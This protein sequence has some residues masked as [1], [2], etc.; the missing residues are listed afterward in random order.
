MVWPQSWGIHFR[1]TGG[2]IVSR[3][4]SWDR[5]SALLFA[6]LVLLVAF[7]F[8]QY[9]N[10]FDAEVQDVYGR[11]IVS[12][13]ASFGHDR[14]AL[15]YIDLFYYGGLFDTLA[16]LVN[17]VSPWAHWATRHL[18]EAIFG[19]IGLGGCWA[20]ARR[21]GGPVAGFAAL[22]MLALMP[23]YYG[24]MF[25]NPKDIPFAAL[26]TWGVY[27]L[28]RIADELP[29]PS[30]KLVAWFG[31]VTGL[32]LGVRI[33][34]VLL[35]VY[36]GLLVL[37]TPGNRLK[38]ALRL[39]P[40]VPLAW[41]VMLVFWPWAMV[42]PIAHPWEAFRHF[43]D[44]NGNIGTL[45]FGRMVGRTYHPDYY[46]PVY[47][48]VKLPDLVLAL[49]AGGLVY[50]LSKLRKGVPGRFI[51]V[52]LAALFPL[53]YTVAT[54]P[55]LYDADRHFLFVLPALAVLAGLTAAKLRWKPAAAAMM[56]LAGW[57]VAQMVSLHPYEYAFFNDV[58][59]GTRNAAGLFETE[60]WGTSLAEGTDD[61]SH[62][63]AAHHLDGP[64]PWRVAVCGK[65]SQMGD[66]NDPHIQPTTDWQHADFFVATTRGACDQRL[67]GRQIGEVQRDGVPFAIVK[68]LRHGETATIVKDPHHGGAG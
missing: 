66:E 18:L 31:L 17:L 40:A 41:A 2:V 54:N 39:A 49:L 13:Y 25:I 5:A 15:S 27:L 29:L 48:A 53:L 51:P 61:L 43:S 59:G 34:G 50:G 65:P 45:F 42:S 56:L 33:G 8:G 35:F 9:G 63:L 30:W 22:A 46:L 37:A 6:S 1:S 32:A 19:L 52:L 21:L 4:F 24:M 14:S 20:V 36:L 7:T 28:T 12:W 10:G 58:A 16:A 23:S 55:Q 26:M 67:Q 60:Y 62:Y 64:K 57:Q 38:M 68:D 11:Q 3:Y 47:M 44:M